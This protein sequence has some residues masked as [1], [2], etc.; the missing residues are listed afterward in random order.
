MTRCN[1]MPMRL[2]HCKNNLRTH[3]ATRIKFSGILLQRF[4]LH[5]GEAGCTVSVHRSNSSPNVMKP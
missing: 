2:L 4:D 1:N 5:Q 3:C